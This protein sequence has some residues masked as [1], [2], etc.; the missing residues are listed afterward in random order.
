LSWLT[1]LRKRNAYRKTFYG[2]DINKVAAMTQDD[3]QKILDTTPTSNS[4]SNSNSNNKNDIVV[5]HKGK[6]ES[7]IHNARCI[8]QMRNQEQ[9]RKQQEDDDDDDN[10]GVFDKFIWS[11][12]DDKPI[13]KKKKKNDINT[14]NRKDI[15]ANSTSPESYAMSKA[16][17]KQWGFKFVG[18]T[19]CYSMMQSIG[20]VIDHPFGSQEWKLAYERLK[21]R[22]NGY[23][24]KD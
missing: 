8:Q 22:P 12:I 23:Q 24:Y 7:I 19:T 17:K 20:M 3:V 16:L 14:D 2:F 21:K 15:I 5:R 9:K 13:I 11:F 6:I 10:Y 4:N 1:I 18:P